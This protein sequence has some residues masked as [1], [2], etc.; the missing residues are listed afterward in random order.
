MSI[1]SS[2]AVLSVLATPMLAT[3][4]G[5]ES[6]GA[7]GTSSTVVSSDAPTPAVFDPPPEHEID[8]ITQPI[9]RAEL[10]RMVHNDQVARSA[11][12]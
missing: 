9:L 7:G 8:K 3:A 11:G 12:T 4:D 6:E 5:L 10:L 1:R 2:V